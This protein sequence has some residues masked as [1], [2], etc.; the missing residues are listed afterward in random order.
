MYIFYLLISLC[1]VSA[2]PVDLGDNPGIPQ[3]LAAIADELHL[4]TKALSGLSSEF[5]KLVTLNEHNSL[6][7]D[8][9]FYISDSFSLL[10]SNLKRFADSFIGLKADL[11][12]FQQV[13]LNYSS[14]RQFDVK[15]ADTLKI[16]ECPVNVLNKELPVTLKNEFFDVHI[17][18]E[19]PVILETPLPLNITFVI[20]E[21][22][23][24]PDSSFCVKLGNKT[25]CHKQ[26]GEHH[27]SK[28]SWYNPFD[29]VSG[30][31]SSL[32]EGM[33][34]AFE[35]LIDPVIEALIKAITPIFELILSLIVKQF[36]FFI[37]LIKDFIDDIITKS[38][39]ELISLF[40]FVLKFVKFLLNIFLQILLRLLSKLPP[41]VLT[42]LS[43]VVLMYLVLKNFY[44]SAIFS[45]P[46][47][48]SN[49]IS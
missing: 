6:R 4:T 38:L 19:I 5:D 22:V 15:F 33:V 41:L 7:F 10:N 49:L 21:N 12:I 24:R 37:K 14:N 18:K 2:V 27:R 3:F 43:S 28:R 29:W 20:D 17:N 40:D 25:K 16:S 13:F 30:A 32:L 46:V 48:L 26:G 45:L 36:K 44:L 23:N 35:F 8:R 47:L 1:L 31:I 34:K 42:F 11:F 9:L 39:D